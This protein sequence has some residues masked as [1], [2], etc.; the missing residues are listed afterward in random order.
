MPSAAL[1]SLVADLRQIFGERLDAVVRYGWRTAPQPVLVL[2]RTLEIDDLNACAA[3][4]RSWHKAEI[5]TP[6]M[7]TSSD[8]ER[9]L[10]AFPIE[11]GDIIASHEVIDGRNPFTGLSIRPEDLRRAC[12]VQ[13]KSH[14][15][16]VREDYLEAAGHPGHIDS[17]VRDSAAGFIA[18]L[19]HLARLDGTTVDRAA[20]VARFA[21]QRIGLDQHIVDNLG[22]LASDDGPS[23]VDAIRVFPAYLKN[24]ERLAEFVDRWRTA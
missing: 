3:R 1:V 16:H 17:L 20:D 10:D 15:L 14:L 4:V 7:L 22:A 12:E 9:S 24:L 18:V 2:V 6:L 21:H 5:A 13:V 23:A 8:F 19:R 11:Y